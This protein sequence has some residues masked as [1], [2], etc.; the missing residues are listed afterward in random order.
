MSVLPG[1]LDSE[2]RCPEGLFGTCSETPASLRMVPHGRGID[3]ARACL[4]FRLDLE[5][6]MQIVSISRF[7]T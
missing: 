5:N 1:S 3:L 4:V 6:F 2:L 7:W